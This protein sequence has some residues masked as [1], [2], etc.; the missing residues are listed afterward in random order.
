MD[1]SDLRSEHGIFLRQQR[2]KELS[3][4]Y[5][6]ERI[7]RTIKLDGICYIY[8]EPLVMFSPL[9]KQNTS[10]SLT[11]ELLERDGSKLFE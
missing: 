2:E 8:I 4:I 11:S 10:P 6:T 9:S 1:L 3:G 5:Y 7:K